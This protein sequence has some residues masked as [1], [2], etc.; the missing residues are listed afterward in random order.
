MAERV[1]VHIGV[2]KAGSTYLQ[3]ILWASQDDLRVDGILVPGHRGDHLAL[4][5]W[6]RGA[7]GHDDAAASLL[8]RVRR[9]PGTVILSSEWFAMADRDQVARFVDAFEGQRLDVVLTAR[10][11]WAAA[12]SAWQQTLKYGRSSSLLEFVA[13][14]EPDTDRIEWEER[15]G[16][17]TM[18]PAVVLPRW[19]TALPEDA[20][21]LVTVPP[22]G[23]GPDLLWFRF[24]Q[25]CRIEPKHYGSLASP[26]NSSLSAE[27]ACLL[28]QLGPLLRGPGSVDVPAE[29]I[30]TYLS[31]RLLASHRGS[32]IELDPDS[33]ELVRRRATTSYGALREARYHAVGDLNDLLHETARPGARTVEDVDADQQLALALKVIPP[34]LGRVVAERRRADRASRPATSAAGKRGRTR[35]PGRRLGPSRAWAAARRRGRRLSARL[36]S[37]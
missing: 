28:R 25:A 4:A 18:D 31:E 8:A 34:L 37:H 33:A 22:P 15:W 12:P 6:T 21:H 14:M 11:Y 1:C 13:G 10:S 29:W 16:W 2:P 24:A 27:A 26:A 9:W 35:R 19:R 17:G 20:V 7:R 5:H 32:P 30:R 23:S 36:G 3:G